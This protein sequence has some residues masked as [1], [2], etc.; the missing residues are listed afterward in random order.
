LKW[1]GLNCAKKQAV[2]SKRKKDFIARRTRNGAEVSLCMPTV[3]QER[4]GKKK[5]PAR[6]A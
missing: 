3:S 2:G 1:D 5:A 6:Y 4:N